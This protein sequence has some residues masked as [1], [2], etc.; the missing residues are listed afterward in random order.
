[1]DDSGI[2]RGFIVGHVLTEHIRHTDVNAIHAQV[3]HRGNTHRSLVRCDTSDIPRMVEQFYDQSEQ[4]PFRVLLSDTSDSAIGLVGLPESNETWIRAANLEEVS[5][6]KE[7]ERSPMRTCEFEFACD[8]SPEKLIPFFQSLPQE[9][10]L[11]LYG[12]DDVLEISCPRCG[13]QFSI[14]REDLSPVN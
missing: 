5:Q 1:M 10:L 11:E 4:Y 8:C 14:R 2:A 13:K 3:S 9:S 12:A 6:S 7:L